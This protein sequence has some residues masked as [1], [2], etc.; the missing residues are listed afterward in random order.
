METEKEHVLTRPGIWIRLIH[1]T[2]PLSTYAFFFD[3]ADFKH[4]LLTLTTGS[5]ELSFKDHSDTAKVSEIHYLDDDCLIKGADSDSVVKFWLLRFSENYAQATTY[6]VVAEAS[7]ELLQG[8]RFPILADSDTFKILKRLLQLLHKH[9]EYITSA[10]S[11]TICELTFNLLF[12]CFAELQ[13]MES[14]GGSKHL[15]RKELVAMRFFNLLNRY[16]SQ[17]HDVRY[18]A[19]ELCM[20]QGNL[21]KV[22]KQVT[23]KAPKTL[24][25][26]HLINITKEMLDTTVVS[27]YIIAEGTGFKSSSAFISFFKAQTGKS[28]NEYRNRNTR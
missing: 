17:H 1:L 14:I 19:R 25:E 8:Q 28:P 3:D 24:I 11:A 16:A 6:K 15:L 2:A 18:Y 23:G 22:I 12:S 13:Q 5:V 10:Y 7:I 27:I 21:A 9:Q 26:E 4:T 20:A